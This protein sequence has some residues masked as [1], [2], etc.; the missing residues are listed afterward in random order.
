MND[1]LQIARNDIN[2]A[3][4]LF[5]NKIYSNAIYFYHQAVEKAVKYLGL[6]IGVIDTDDLRRKISH[7]PI[8]VF[9]ILDEKENIFGGQGIDNFASI[10]KQLTDEQLVNNTLSEIEK[11][12]RNLY[13]LDS[14]ISSFQNFKNYIVDK[15]FE[16]KESLL[17]IEENA[18]YNKMASDF[19]NQL[20]VGATIMRMLFLNSCLCTKYSLDSYRY[21]STE[22]GDPIE[23]FSINNPI[24]LKLDIFIKSV[25]I[26]LSQLN[27]IKW[28]NEKYS[29]T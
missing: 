23:Y 10:I 8:K 29:Q 21:S 28:E 4:L 5:N 24:I 7:N 12:T 26:C 14:N 19:F 27:V 25:K 9:K 6:R 1:L 15:N 17:S 16:E 2:T 11:S 20:N 13:D 3:E 22:V 18:Y